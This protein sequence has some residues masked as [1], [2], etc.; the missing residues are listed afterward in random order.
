MFAGQVVGQQV[1]TFLPVSII[2]RATG[3]CPWSSEQ[4][5]SLV[6]G[7]RPQTHSPENGG[8]IFCFR[9]V[10]VG[11]AGSRAAQRPPGTLYL[12]IPKPEQCTHGLGTRR[13]DEDKGGLS[14]GA[15]Q[16]LFSGQPVPANCWEQTLAQWESRVGTE[17]R[18]FIYCLY[19]LRLWGKKSGK[20]RKLPPPQTTA[21]EAGLSC[22]GFWCH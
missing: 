1:P 19:E 11:A 20:K 8:L 17:W 4:K 15:Q 2:R 6:K 10:F 3:A 12:F 18:V 21:S 13:E 5:V 7:G 9:V 22:S 14:G 16:R